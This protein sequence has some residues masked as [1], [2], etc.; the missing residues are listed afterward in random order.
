MGGGDII[1]IA[2][3]SLN[4]CVFLEQRKI[5]DTFTHCSLWQ[6]IKTRQALNSREGLRSHIMECVCVHTCVKLEIR[7]QAWVRLKRACLGP[8]PAGTWVPCIHQG[9]PAT[10]PGKW[11]GRHGVRHTATAQWKAKAVPTTISCHFGRAWDC[12]SGS[13]PM[14]SR[15]PSL[16]QLEGRS[17]T[18]L[19]R[20]SLY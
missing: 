13:Q 17:G 3:L 15:K 10:K 6:W 16:R 11:D 2:L 5:C 8:S 4:K 18:H 19:C 9:Q 12:V 20:V 1:Y 14:R 7:W